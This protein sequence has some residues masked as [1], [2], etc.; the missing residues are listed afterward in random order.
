[1]EVVDGAL[2]RQLRQRALRPE[3]TPEQPIPGD[4]V[5]DA[6]HL[7]AL[8][9]DG[10]VVGACWVR[11]ESCDWRPDD[12]PAWRLRAMATAA[13]HRGLGVGSALIQGARECAASRG[14]VLLWCH[15]RLAAEPFYLGLGWQ[16]HG[17]L[18]IEH[19]L[20]HRN[21][22]LPLQPPD[23]SCPVAGG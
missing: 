3:Q 11:A 19:A 23:I 15:A 7:A 17:E 12:R 8:R 20:P 4:G 13:D 18:F 16:P 22:W 5:E 1:M 14:G 6:I 10:S 9:E 21:M 2:T